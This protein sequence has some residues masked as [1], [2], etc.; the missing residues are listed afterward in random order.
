MAADPA[1]VDTNVL[2][3]ATRPSAVQHTVAQA[4]LTRFE[5]E[6]S[7]LWI[8]P[9]VLREY[10]AVV[11]RPQATA[12]A[13]PIASAI[14]DVQRFRTVFSIAEER[15]NVLDRL[16]DLLAV[17]NGS[18]RQIHDA[19]IVATMLEHGIRRLLTFNAADFRRFARIIDIE[20]LS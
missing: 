7:A 10:L 11:T 13:L 9:Q 17:H 18:G 5:D 4:T 2:V 20:P 8:S 14:A 15:P 1:F 19:N 12:P 16:L 3:Y 6:G